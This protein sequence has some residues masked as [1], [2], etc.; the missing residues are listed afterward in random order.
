MRNTR[1]GSVNRGR[2]GL[3]LVLMLLA[4]LV[5]PMSAWAA[6]A[7]S[8]PGNTEW[9][10]VYTVKRGDTLSAIAL[11][12]GV[13]DEALL[14]ANSL[15]NANV[16]YVGQQLII[17]EKSNYG[18]G[19]PVCASYYTVRRGDTLSG[20]ALYN[21]IDQYALARANGLYDL[22]DVFVGQTLCIPGSSTPQQPVQPQ[23][24]VVEP[25]RPADG[26]QCNPCEAP[27][28]DAPKNEGPQRPADGPQRPADGPQCNPCNAGN[29]GPQR[30]ADG[31]QRPS[32][33]S[34]C[35]SC[36][37]P[38]RP[39]GDRPRYDDDKKHEPLR[40]TE[41]W[42][43]TYFSDKYFS[44][45]AM[46]RQDLEVNFNWMIGSPFGDTN[47]DRFSVRWEK[48]E[49]FKGGPYRFFAVA[50]DGVRVYVDDQLIIDAWVIQPATE[51]KADLNLSDGPHKVVVEYYEEAE[52]AQI[53]VYWEQRRHNK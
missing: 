4:S 7:Q 31:P 34:Q 25:Q 33:G 11:S 45:F 50:D 20:I 9:V 53:H 10:Q 38:E 49:Y 35:N 6:P 16:I 40:P 3:V 48:V 37:G 18:T 15:R 8:N 39:D 30:P 41:F 14:Q 52:D 51:Y 47:Q 2:M 17:P 24:P 12:F 46:E 43:G 1:L 22:N 21:G 36:G 19:G 32:D 42:K 23:R 27:K 44:E 5:A 28:K 13:S 29:E 26:P